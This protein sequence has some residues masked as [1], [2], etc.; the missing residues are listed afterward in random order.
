[1]RDGEHVRNGAAESS[2]GGAEEV[3][4]CSARQPWVWK[5][6]AIEREVVDIGRS[7]A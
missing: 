2:T 7:G 5:K 4:M 3:K 1:V 6:R